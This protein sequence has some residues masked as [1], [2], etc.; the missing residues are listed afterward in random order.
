MSVSPDP[1]RLEFATLR[2][3]CI[4]NDAGSFTA[5]AEAIGVNQSAVSYS[6]ERLRSVFHDPLFVREKGQQVATQRCQ[7]IIE[8]IR[9]MLAALEQMAR[10]DAFD[11]AHAR[12]R[13]VLAC[14]YYERVLVIPR[15]VREMRLRAPGIEIAV[16]NSRGA[17]PELLLRGEADMLIGPRPN[18]QS[19]IY[20]SKLYREDYVCLMDHAHPMAGRD[21][22]IEDYLALDLIDITYEGNWTSTYVTQILAQGYRMTPTLRVPSPAGVARLVS[23]S[24]LVA[25]VPRRLAQTFGGRVKIVECPFRGDFD[26]TMVWPLRFHA[27]AMHQ[28]IR[29]LIMELRGEFGPSTHGTAEI[30]SD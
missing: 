13:L 19:G 4:V 28:W 14:N 29:G 23:G 8:Q 3:L 11:P 22:T 30:L 15:L 18:V 26:L 17:G 16:I 1:M 27:D 5:A 6:I 10:P 20:L 7:Q 9:P 21:L 2:T 12:G 25:T 24:T